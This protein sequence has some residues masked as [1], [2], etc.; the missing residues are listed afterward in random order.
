MK[1][2]VL[3]LN[4]LSPD[5][6]REFIEAGDLPNF[7]RLRDESTLYTTDAGEDPPNLEPWIQWITV[8][9]GVPFSE[10]QIF[11]LG[12]AEE[13][14]SYPGIG[15]IVS[16]SGAS[17]GICGSM[18]A[19]YGDLRGYVVPDPWSKAGHPQPPWLAGYYNF[20]ASRVQESSRNGGT[21]LASNARFATTLLRTGLSVRTA[22]ETARQLI[23]ERIDSGVS[24]RKACLLDLYQYDVFRGLNARYG[25]S[26]ATYFSNCVAHY[27]HYYW[28]NM[29]PD[30]FPTPPPPTDHPSLRD[31]IRTGFKVNDGIVGRVLRDYPQAIIVFC[32][33]LSQI[34]WTETQ[35]VTYRPHDFKRLLRFAGIDTDMVQVFPVMAEQFHVKCQDTQHASEVATLLQQIHVNGSSAM[36]ARAEGD[37]VFAGCWLFAPQAVSVIATSRGDQKGTRF[38]DLFY[39]I[40]T[41]RSGQHAR[42]GML[43][44]RSGRKEPVAEAVS[45]AAIAP[46]ILSA[47]G[48][49]PPPYMKEHP[50][51]V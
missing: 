19:G 9:T 28:R 27:Q 42:P 35:K 17:V 44:I 20:V 40:H 12:D 21:S 48:I 49:Q 8:H 15:R 4:E 25:V 3:E 33:A 11:H 50:L 16:D 26:F 29:N 46:T 51:Q 45:V 32:T 30:L 38:A 7:Q 2:I 18:N 14:L 39:M 37:N 22:W 6:M 41:M 10:H 47:L 24:W 5:L 36:F 34:P 43:W 13:K 1:L 31:A 23:A